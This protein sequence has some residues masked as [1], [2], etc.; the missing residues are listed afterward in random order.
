M[1]K[2]KGEEKGKEKAGDYRRYSIW[3]NYRVAYGWMLELQGANY[4][5]ITGVAIVI[6]VIQPF[7]AIAL[8][9]AVVYL[10]GS[11]WEPGVILLVLAAYVALLQGL[12]AAKGYLS[13]RSH[14]LQFR[15][16]V[17]LGPQF[18]K[19]C[20]E[21]D[22][23]R[24][25]SERGQKKLKAAHRNLYMGNQE[26]IEEF[27]KS[28]EEC[29][30]NL[31]GVIL[32]SLVIGRQNI[33]I[34]LL[35]ILSSCIMWVIYYI[36]NKRSV[37]Y[38]DKYEK[39]WWEG[40]YLGTEALTPAN[41]KDI[42]MYHMWNWFSREFQ[43]IR[44]E[45]I[46]LGSK[47]WWCNRGIAAVIEKGIAFGRDILVYGYLI[48]QVAQGSITLSVFL[49]YIG[50]ISGFGGWMNPLMNTF[51]RMLKNNRNMDLYR[52]F[53][54]FAGEVGGGADPV[55]R[56][57]QPHEIR[58]EHVSFRY[59]GNENDTIHD[60]SLTIAPGEKI[61]LVGM[62]GAGKSTLIKLICGLYRPS[63]GRIYLDG[64]DI[65]ELS[66]LEYRKEFGV[67]FQEVFAFSFSLEGNVSCKELR[68][69]DK[70]R[71]NFSLQ[72][73]GLWDKVQELEKKECTYMNKEMDASGVTLSGGE[74][75]KLMLA[76]ALYKDA[77]VL[78]LDEPTAALD[79]IAESS[80]YEKYYGMTREKTSIFIS[81]RLSS[82]KF[83]DHI[84]FMEEGRIKEEGSHQEL[85]GKQGAYAMMFHTQ[86]QYY[87][88]G[89]ADAKKCAE[90]SIRRGN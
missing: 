84:L 57:G 59:E 30:V 20:M 61:A 73:A 82:T 65:T 77:P 68:S 89:G 35:L 63:S 78:I 87:E 18:A 33:W 21:A 7:L 32:Y 54:E 46:H 58:L 80:L 53:L 48:Y 60:M 79:P 83:C 64:K 88:S 12:Q 2:G 11:G 55:E 34:L 27:V 42:R 28:L 90:E 45:F 74:L 29:I 31:L 25:E 72:K 4:F 75:Q 52:D 9:G 86:A 39:A 6:S 10:L 70:D 41:G 13:G 71:L 14:C 36:S 17:G 24:I 26:G 38:D 56:P 66:D 47:W 23:E 51:S 49:L 69:G 22:Y 67:V 85:M 16:R 81:H 44:K 43:Q 5:A 19:A 76:R 3:D 37:T 8:P 40:N 15:L 1:R 62:N 50:I